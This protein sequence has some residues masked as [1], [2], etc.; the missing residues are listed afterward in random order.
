M[1]RYID[2]LSIDTNELSIIQQKQIEIDEEQYFCE[3]LT[4]ILVHNGEQIQKKEKVMSRHQAAE[5]NKKLE[6]RGH[7]GRWEVK[8]GGLD[9]DFDT[10]TE[11]PFWPLNLLQ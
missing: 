6:K 5:E 11:L 1:S 3:P 9:I 8:D 10:E 4:F 2:T 7:L